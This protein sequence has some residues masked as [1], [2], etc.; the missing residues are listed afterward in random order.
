MLL[1]YIY[2][3]MYIYIYIYIFIYIYIYI[4]ID[5]DAK[6][7]PLD[8]VIANIFMIELESVLVPKLNDHWNWIEINDESR[9]AYND[10]DDDNNNNN[11]SD[12]T[13]NIKFKTPMIRSNLFDYSD[14]YIC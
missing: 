11:N 7:S 8:P 3:Y 13:N 14:A 6:G 2:I 12:N 1:I 4:Q 5:G 9:R 10:D